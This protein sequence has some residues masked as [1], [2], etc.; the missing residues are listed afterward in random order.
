MLEEGNCGG[1]RRGRISATD[2]LSIHTAQ[3]KSLLMPEA[4]AATSAVAHNQNLQQM[5]A[6]VRATVAPVVPDMPG[7]YTP[8]MMELQPAPMPVAVGF[9]ALATAPMPS[10]TVLRTQPASVPRQAV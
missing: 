6:G 7:S 8:P 4:H 5:P 2:W 9:V 10:A 1:H 3:G